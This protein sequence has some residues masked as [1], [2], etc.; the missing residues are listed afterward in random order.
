MLATRPFPAR[1]RQAPEDSEFEFRITNL[2]LERPVWRLP[3]SVMRMS[4]KKGEILEFIS[5][6]CLIA[7][8]VRKRVWF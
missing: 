5:S 4:S 6:N 3:R 8:L 2:N 7:D 1:W